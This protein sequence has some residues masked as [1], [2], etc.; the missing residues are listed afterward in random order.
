MIPNIV[1]LLLLFFLML[2]SITSVNVTPAVLTTGE[3]QVYVEANVSDTVGIINVFSEAY[4]ASTGSWTSEVITLNL[5]SGDSLNGVYGENIVFPPDV[6]DGV[7]QIA[8]VASNSES[9]EG[10]WE[11]Y[12]QNIDGIVTLERGVTG[13]DTIPPVF[14]SMT[15]NPPILT[16][17]QVEATV[18]VTA[19]DD[20]GVLS[21]AGAV[22][23]RDTLLPVSVWNY[24]WS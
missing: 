13:S 12:G 4:D 7:Y 3:S 15:V 19:T 21:V 9:V 1:I 10:N 23:N 5:V 8:V 22:I 24:I 20:A 14:T 17:G 18:T 16:A 11:T 6:K 2:P